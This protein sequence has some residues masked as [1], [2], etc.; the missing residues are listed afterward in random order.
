MGT[1]FKIYLPQSGRGALKPARPKNPDFPVAGHETILLVE[2]EEA[3]RRSCHEFLTSSGYR[4]L[5]ARDGQHALKVAREH[6]GHID[7]L[8]SDVVMPHLSGGELAER[9]MQER[10]E[11][12][13]LFVSGYAEKTVLQHGV[14]DLQSGFL[15]KPFSL[16]T[17][18]RSMREVLDASGISCPSSGSVAELHS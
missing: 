13:V 3:V 14:I 10:P 9:L 12:K 6:V 5:E 18:A 7:L 2:D 11:M 17:L 8:V 15:Q 4:V 16:K 1:S